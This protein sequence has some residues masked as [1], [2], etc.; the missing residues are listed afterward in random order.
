MLLHSAC[1]KIPSRCLG[2]CSSHSRA[3]WS[4]VVRGGGCEPSDCS[5]SCHT[6][7]T[8]QF[9]TRGPQSE[10]EHHPVLNTLRVP[11][12][13][14]REALCPEPRPLVQACALQCCRHLLMRIKKQ[15]W[16]DLMSSATEDRSATTI[17]RRKTNPRGRHVWAGGSRPSARREHRCQRL[18]RHRSPPA[19]LGSCDARRSPR[20][21]SAAWARWS[22]CFGREW[23]K[24]RLV[25]S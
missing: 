18:P 7:A 4:G 10:R 24:R 25:S 23:E 15:C 13:W 9:V 3:T 6:A 19:R 2:R 16:S 8:R 21:T 20:M 22:I 12:Q 1:L 14:P 5:Q 17:Q 11:S